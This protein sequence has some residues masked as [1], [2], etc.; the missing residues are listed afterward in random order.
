[1]PLPT[2][3]VIALRYATRGARRADNFLG[4]DPHDG[5]MPMDYFFWVVRNEERL[6]LV[7]TGF[8]ED[9]AVKRHRTLLRLPA[10]G[11]KLLDIDPGNVRTI[12][13]THLHNDHIG[14]FDR[15]PVAAFHLQ[16]DEMA[17][18]TGR[19]MRHARLR[20]S[21]EPDHVAGM[22]RLVFDD[23][24]T[25]H[26]GD[27]AIAP[28]ISVHQVAGHSPGMQCVRIHTR[29]GWV[30][31]ASDASHYYEHLEQRRVFPVVV[32]VGGVLESYDRLLALADS[33][34]H[35]VPGHDPLVMRRYPP[36]AGLE[37]IAVRLDADPLRER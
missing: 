16:D 13:V 19:Y 2:Y 37:G 20:R 33:P 18:A 21:Y 29:R 34:D 15:F 9:M 36:V 14:A 3:E 31:L 32:D 27:G 12:V 8:C 4:G 17:F 10:D 6:V 35:V 23:R 1:M 24:V 26:K 5:E 22:V 25:F 30:V 11:L 28:G 7:D